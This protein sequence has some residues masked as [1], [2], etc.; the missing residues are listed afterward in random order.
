MHFLH[1]RP[2][3]PYKPEMSY[4]LHFRFMF[5]STLLPLEHKYIYSIPEKRRS[6]THLC[7]LHEISLIMA[8]YFL[9]LIFKLSQLLFGGSDD[10]IIVWK[11]GDEIFV[12]KSNLLVSYVIGSYFFRNIREK[13]S[14]TQRC[15]H[16]YNSISLIIPDLNNGL[17]NPKT[18]ALRKKCRRL[19]NLPVWTKL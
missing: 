13:F 12:C 11:S 1:S 18:H 15:L 8:I 17:Q 9:I 16:P 14:S 19:K 2:E 4:W 7:N 10:S 5:P 3:I 6:N